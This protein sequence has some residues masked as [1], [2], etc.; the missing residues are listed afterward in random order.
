M[1]ERRNT[2]DL[3]IVNIDTGEEVEIYDVPCAPRIHEKVQWRKGT[4]YIPLIV[5]GVIWHFSD[6]PHYEHHARI[7]AGK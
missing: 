1:M 3:T 4:N 7:E 6:E 5:Y 2:L